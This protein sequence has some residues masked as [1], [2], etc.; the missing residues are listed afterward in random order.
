MLSLTM[1]AE[2]Y[3][4]VY[5]NHGKVWLDKKEVVKGMVID[6]DK[7]PKLTW[8]EDGQIIK[9]INTRNNRLHIITKEAV[10]KKGNSS[11]KDLLVQS[12]DLSI[13]GAMP[14]NHVMLA[15]KLN[16]K[17]ALLQEINIGGI[18]RVS[19]KCFYFVQYQWNGEMV[20]KKIRTVKDGFGNDML[21]LNSELYIIDDVQQKP[22]DTTMKLV[23]Y[24]ES[25]NGDTTVSV[26]VDEMVLCP[27]VGEHCRQYL[28]SYAG[29]DLT[30]AEWYLLADQFLNVFYPEMAFFDTDLE[31]VIPAN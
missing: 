27:S 6:T 4:V 11:L 19:D 9:V 23:C 17:I 5:V 1:V 24:E 26:V 8:T 29:S 21:V 15:Q 2:E 18:K 30:A 31:K 12:K 22:F 13:R 16:K 3:K 20:N 25:P 10:N 7:N 28:A 14:M